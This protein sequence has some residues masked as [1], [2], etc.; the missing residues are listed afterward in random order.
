MTQNGAYRY[1]VPWLLQGLGPWQ[2]RSASAAWPLRRHTRIALAVEIT[3]LLSAAG[4][5]LGPYDRTILFQPIADG[6]TKL[7]GLLI[8][9]GAS[10]TG[11][12]EGFTPTELAKACCQRRRQ[13]Q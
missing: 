11:D 5:K 3:K 7:V 13:D 2:V 1:M 10:V 9:K 12:L 4:A 8:D 6:N